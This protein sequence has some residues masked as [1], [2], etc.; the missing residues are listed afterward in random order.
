MKE[1]VKVIFV[2]YIGLIKGVEA[3]SRNSKREEVGEVSG[4]LKALSKEL[5]VPVIALAQ[6]KRTGN[7]YNGRSGETEAPR[8]TL[9][10]LKESGDLE[11]DADAVILLHRTENET[12]AII[13][14]NRNGECGQVELSFQEEVTSFTEAS[15]QP[16]Y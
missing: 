9:E 11:Q 12:C 5:G 8:P 7:A 6:L 13:A 16:I 2:D 1:G 4:G 15:I 3:K 10:S 14:K